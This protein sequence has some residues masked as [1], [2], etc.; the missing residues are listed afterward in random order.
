M[1]DVS[2]DGG[3]TKQVLQE[4]TGP[5]CQAGEHVFVHYKGSL[6]N[7][8]IFDA[9][10]GKPHREKYGFYFCLGQGHV[11]RAWDVGFLKM[12]VGEKAILNC[13]GDYSYG[14]QGMPGCGIG[15]NAT[16]IYEIEILDSRK[17]TEEEANAIGDEVESLRR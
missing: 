15:P 10:R 8:E 9:S 4:G 1:T 13:R 16:L 6:E 14:E 2:G 7:G 11:I 5:V 17:L 3:V 12:K